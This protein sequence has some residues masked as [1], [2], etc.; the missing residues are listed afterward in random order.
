MCHC[1]TSSYVAFLDYNDKTVHKGD[2]LVAKT[3]FLAYC[4]SESQQK[5]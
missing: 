4:I 2:I 1:K 3:M 5:L